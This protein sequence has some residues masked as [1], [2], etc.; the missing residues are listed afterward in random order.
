[1]GLEQMIA[2]VER[3][4][5]N[6]QKKAKEFLY[7]GYYYDEK[8]RFV[9]KIGTTND[10]KRRRYEHNYNYRK[11][12]GAAR[13]PKENSFEYIWTLKLSGPNTRNYEDLNKALWKDLSFG[14]YLDN[15]RFIFEEKP[16]LAIVKIKKYYE[17]SLEGLTK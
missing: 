13:M 3:M 17:I 14:E 9:L 4:E 2:A 16:N 11:S 10:L 1:M 15:D 7:V 12:N 5:A 8:G 6:K